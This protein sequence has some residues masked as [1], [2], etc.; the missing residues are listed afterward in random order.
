MITTPNIC[1]FPLIIEN[2]GLMIGRVPFN[3][4]KDGTLNFG[5]AVKKG[6]RIRLSYGAQHLILSE[7][8]NDSKE[9]GRFAPQGMFMV[10]CGNRLIFLK[11][12]EKKEIDYYRRICPDLA[13]AHGNSEIYRLNGKGGEL[14]S[15]LVAVGIREGEKDRSVLQCT[16]PPYQNKGKSVLVPLEHR[17]MTFMHAVTN[18]LEEMTEKANAANEAKSSFL[19]NMSHEIRTPLNAV[20]GMNEM[21]LREC[22]DEQIL[23]Y[24]E[25]IRTAGNTLLGLINDILDFSKIEA[26]RLDIIPVDYDLA[27]LLNDLV[28]MIKI[29]ADAKGLQ[30]IVN[31]DPAT[32]SFLHGDEIRL[33]QIVTNILTNAVKY[34]KQGSV[35][36][37]VGFTAYDDGSV[38]L[39]FSVEDTGI[40]IKQ[41]DM[42]KLFEAFERIEEERNRAIEG[43][44]LGMN[45]TRRLLTM[46]GSK[47]EAQSEYGK[48]SVFSFTVRQEVVRNEPVGDFSAALTRTSAGR[49]SRRGRSFTAPDAN[50]LVVDDT[51]MNLTVFCSL[52]KHTKVQTDTAGS[53][54][55][56]LDLTARKKYDIIFLDHR[57][58]D[59]DGIETLT[60]LRSMP[61]N[62]NIETTAVCLTANAVSGAKEEYLAA[63]FDDYLT[64]PIEPE[65]LEAMLLEYL[66]KKKI[67]AE[68][69]EEPT[70]PVSSV[71]PEWLTTIPEIDTA[72]GIKHC[73]NEEIYLSTLQTYAEAVKDAADE[74]ER[75]WNVN[76]IKNVT[77]K[78]HALK[79]TSRVIGAAD[80]GAFAE[81]LEA[82]GNNGDAET[83]QNELGALLDR[84]RKLG[85]ALSPL[86]AQ[87]DDALPLITDDELND[88]YT[89]IRECLSVADFDSAM[90]VIEDM[91]GYRFPENE[92]DR[93][94]KLKKA[95]SEVDYDAIA[96]ILA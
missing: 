27:S 36:M 70:Q 93:F 81:R 96:K 85:A 5:A 86:T 48:G 87:D 91:S 94:A 76:D 84:Y 37:T 39:R 35:T 65:K 67:E 80:L 95:A 57:M 64:K 53:G 38:G 88:A 75:F 63:G 42:G 46:M 62:L 10:V 18:D 25:N 45:I 43:T 33:K 31:V 23:T 8:Y 58:P 92:K 21:I 28:N 66:P 3:S 73:G 13:F 56:C 15:A 52:L 4:T 71:I 47:L 20:L 59:K 78:V 83:L 2:D 19:S 32:P 72:A 6:S 12:D 50:V 61:D 22:D 54:Q 11:D 44:G 77:I 40:G 9:F 14:H 49:R 60:E 69:T 79:S 7:T 16:V 1:E 30:L 90:Q 51:K 89:L 74:I 17:V 24:A 55:E 82:A 29:R 41:E 26:G 34:T 68:G